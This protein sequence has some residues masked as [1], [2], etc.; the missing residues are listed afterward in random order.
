MKL[1]RD[2][3]WL[4]RIGESSDDTGHPDLL[5]IFDQVG[6]RGSH[7]R[8]CRMVER[9]GPHMAPEQNGMQGP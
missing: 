8:G 2:S 7:E 4:A 1:V 3:P 9:V 5:K 6:R